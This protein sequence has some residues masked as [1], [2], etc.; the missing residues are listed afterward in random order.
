M[1]VLDSGGNRNAHD[2]ARVDGKQ[3]STRDIALI[4]Q[5]CRGRSESAPFTNSEILSLLDKYQDALRWL[6]ENFNVND[7]YDITPVR[8]AVGRAYYH[9]DHARL[10]RFVQIYLNQVGQDGS[11]IEAVPAALAR[12]IVSEDKNRGGSGRDITARCLRAIQ[13]YMDNK[14]ITRFIHNPE[15]LSI[16]PLPLEVVSGAENV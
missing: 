8:A 11:A 13:A 9:C 6:N 4:R 15:H 5:M 2:A 12:T 16:Y 10:K 14:P 3:C 7:R 1:K